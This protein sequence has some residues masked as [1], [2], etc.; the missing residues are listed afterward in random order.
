[1]GAVIRDV[2]GIRCA[3]RARRERQDDQATQDPNQQTN[4]PSPFIDGLGSS[5]SQ[6]C[7]GHHRDD[8]IHLLLDAERPGMQQSA[9]SDEQVEVGRRMRN[10][11]PVRCVGQRP[12]DV[13]SQRRQLGLIADR[14]ERHH[15]SDDRHQQCRRQS[16]D[17]PNPKPVQRQTVRSAGVGS[18]VISV[19]CIEWGYNSR[20]R[21]REPRGQ[22]DR[23][24]QQTRQCE[25]ERDA[26]EA[27]LDPLKT[28]VKR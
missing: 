23:C 24:D 10:V 16:P 27:T 1:M 12:R 3:E 21:S 4:P 7:P 22:Q 20:G 5:P 9:R 18:G 26:E 13:T 17:P 25:E 19:G 14:P 28:V 8:E 6:T 15:R 11:F 2:N